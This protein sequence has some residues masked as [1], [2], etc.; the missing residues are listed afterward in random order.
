M[1]KLNKPTKYDERNVEF[2]A[3]EVQP[4]SNPAYTN[5]STYGGGNFGGSNFGTGG[6][7]TPSNKN[8][9]SGP[10]F[11]EILQKSQDKQKRR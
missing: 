8:T 1:K 5:G 3:N 9:N 10:S 4:V 2:Y 11:A 7:G 6:G